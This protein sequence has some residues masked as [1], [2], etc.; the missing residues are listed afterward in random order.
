MQVHQYIYTRLSKTESPLDKSGFQSA[1]MPHGLMDRSEAI[2]LESYI[3][4]PEGQAFA[5]KHIVFWREILGQRFLVIYFLD[6]LPGESDEYGRSG[7]F[8]CHGFLIPP[9]L[10]KRYRRPLALATALEAYRYHSIEALMESPYIDDERGTI[11]PI[12]LDVEELTESLPKATPLSETESKLINVLS[13][14]AA[15]H[16]DGPQQLAIKGVPWQVEKVL[17]RVFAY[18]PEPTRVSLGWDS[19]FD[20]GKMHFSPFKVFGYDEEEPVTGTPIKLDLKTGEFDRGEFAGD[21]I[22]EDVLAPTDAF[23][24]WLGQCMEVGA[25]WS[26]LDQMGVLANA[27]EKGEDLPEGLPH[28]G[29]FAIAN[30]DLVKA[31]FRRSLEFTWIPQWLDTLTEEN[32]AESCLKSMVKG[33]QPGDLAPLLLNLFLRL[34]PVPYTFEKAPPAAVVSAG[35][36]LLKQLALMWSSEPVNAEAIQQLKPAERLDWLRL[37]AAS[38][39][40]QSQEYVDLLMAEKEALKNLL[41]EPAIHKR[42]EAHFKSKLWPQLQPLSRAMMEQLLEK[43]PVESYQD[44]TPDWLRV[45][46]NYL[47]TLGIPQLDIVNAAELRHHITADKLSNYPF[48]NA[49]L[50]PHGNV[51]ASMGGDFKRRSACLR[52]LIHG[53]GLQERTLREM[54]FNREEIEDVNPDAGGLFGK[55]RKLFGN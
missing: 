6:D 44:G 47:A 34:K 17:D 54:G 2:E 49:C 37:V 43:E 9:D 4:R 32:P 5:S 50:H 21:K 22:E 18:L 7:N 46:E 27:L 3:H 15:D 35:N 16:E 28:D 13:R 19:G 41:R 51:A 53:H 10:W 52:V 29:C 12:E 48:L 42:M 30:A 8:I 23:T 38:P 55:V 40:S 33:N 25:E 24:R 20:G 11:R 36:G 39:L 31:Q 45:L 1:F 14:L 26:Y